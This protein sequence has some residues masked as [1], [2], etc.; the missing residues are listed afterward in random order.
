MSVP[1]VTPVAKVPGRCPIC[2]GVIS[3]GSPVEYS[4]FYEARVHPRCRQSLDRLQR[5]NKELLAQYR[6]TIGGDVPL[7]KS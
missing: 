3:P 7:V 6:A 4:G 2:G 1:R 5:E